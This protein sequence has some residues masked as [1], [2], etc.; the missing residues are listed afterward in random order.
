[1]LESRYINHI[2]AINHAALSDT[3]RALLE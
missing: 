3:K 2:L 1:V